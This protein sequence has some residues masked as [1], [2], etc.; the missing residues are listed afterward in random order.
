MATVSMATVARK[1][2]DELLTHFDLTGVNWTDAGPPALC[3]P[4][5]HVTYWSP[6]WFA[7]MTV[8]AQTVHVGGLSRHNADAHLGLPASDLPS[9]DD[10]PWV[11]IT[12]G[13]SFNVDPNFFIAAAHA[14]EQLGCLPLLAMGAPL[15]SKLGANDAS[16][17]YP[18]AHVLRPHL[19]FDAFLPHVAA[20]IHHGG[21]GTT[22]ALVMHAVPQLVVPHAAD[23]MRQAQG[24]MRSGVGHYLPAKEVTI[25][26]LVEM[27]VQ[28]LTRPLSLA[29]PSHR[30]ASRISTLWVVFPLRRITSKR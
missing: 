9:P 6:S 12:L 29:Q 13:T 18:L 25:A 4:L 19:D 2:L 30:V 26:R 27:L 15:A 7:D 11:L 21:A 5:R 22:H 3:S 8:G 17:A 10:A 23:Q 16:H 20:A 1:R 28:T 14:A 24:V